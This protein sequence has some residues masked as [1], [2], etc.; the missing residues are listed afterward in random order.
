MCL[1]KSQYVSR[2][3]TSEDARVAL[4]IASSVA[5]CDSGRHRGG[6]CAGRHYCAKNRPAQAPPRCRPESQPAT[7]DAIPSATRASSEVMERD[8]YC[9][10]SKHISAVL[11]GLVAR[12][13]IGRAHV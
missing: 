2:S 10:F 7:E 9:D 4:G 6:A 12:C 1:L 5:G 11:H 13:Q 3:I 8:T